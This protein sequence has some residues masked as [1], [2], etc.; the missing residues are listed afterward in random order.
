MKV[1]EEDEILAKVEKAKWINW[2]NTYISELNLMKYILI[3]FSWVFQSCFLI[4]FLENFWMAI[5]LLWGIG[6]VELSLSLAQL[7]KH[8]SAKKT[9]QT[10]CYC[11]G[12]KRGSFTRDSQLLYPPPPLKTI[13]NG[14]HSH[15]CWQSQ[16]LASA[17]YG[18]NDKKGID[19][20][21]WIFPMRRRRKWKF[22]FLYHLLLI[23]M[24]IAA[25]N[26][27]I[28]YNAGRT[29]R[30]KLW[31]GTI[32]RPFTRIWYVYLQVSAHVR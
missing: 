9:H 16:Y 31:S 8:I 23:L 14:A 11:N 21:R 25:M 26:G 18:G 12:L 29:D 28:E 1:L 2:V 17:V 22:N 13:L 30:K 27:N 6:W 10:E 20:I 19:K 4:T 3:E 15:W 5:K 24:M 32:E 7:T